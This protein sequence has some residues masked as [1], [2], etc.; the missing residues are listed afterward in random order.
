M[1]RTREHDAVSTTVVIVGGGI[2]RLA[3]AHSPHGHVAARVQFAFV[4]GGIRLGGMVATA[5]FSG[6]LVELGPDALLVRSPKMAARVQDFGLDDQMVAPAAQGAQVWARGQLRR[7]PQGTLF[8]VPDWLMPL[9]RSRLLCATRLPRVARDLVLPRRHTVSP[10]TSFA[11]V[12]VTAR[13]VT[14]WRGERRDH[15]RVA[16]CV[17]V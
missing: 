12:V 9:L 3:R 15:R 14:S 7:L 17:L 2:N 16:P 10:D 1:G 6:H 5:E 8:A 11:A 4:E 13:I